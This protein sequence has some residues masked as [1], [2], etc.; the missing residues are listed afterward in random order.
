MRLIDGL[1]IGSLAVS[2]QLWRAGEYPGE[3]TPLPGDASQLEADL[4]NDGRSD[5][6][7]LFLSPD[8]RQLILAVTLGGGYIHYLSTE[9]YVR[10]DGPRLSV[11]G[12]DQRCVRSLRR[13]RPMYCRD[14]YPIPHYRAIVVT[15]A[16]GREVEWRW[17]GAFFGRTEIF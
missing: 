12:V 6:V 11:R 7:G 1:V 10:T 4:N 3:W 13:E 16:D 5:K 15:Y 8:R 14:S 9:R 17:G 2:T